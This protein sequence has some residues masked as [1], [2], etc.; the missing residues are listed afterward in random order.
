[1]PSH[2]VTLVT[3]VADWKLMAL[4]RSGNACRASVSVHDADD[5]MNPAQ[6]FSREGSSLTALLAVLCFHLWS[7]VFAVFAVGLQSGEGTIE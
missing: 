4:I 2:D 3:G 1:M 7:A 6:L 5:P